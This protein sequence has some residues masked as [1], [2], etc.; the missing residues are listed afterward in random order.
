MSS[1]IS[2][3]EKARG[4]TTRCPLCFEGLEEGSLQTCGGCGT[5]YHA[6]C[7]AE[8]GGCSTLGCAERSQGR[9]EPAPAREAAP[10][11]EREER[12]ETILKILV[13]T[14][15]ALLGTGLLSSVGMPFWNALSMGGMVGVMVAFVLVF[16]AQ[17]SD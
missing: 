11:F 5:R 4:E 13:A 10:S 2:Q 9:E 17:S 16:P 6:E 3:R 8:L 1:V 7:H 12:I 15:L 14:V